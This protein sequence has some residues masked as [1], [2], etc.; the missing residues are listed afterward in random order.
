MKNYVGTCCMKLFF[1]YC[2]YYVSATGGW[3]GTILIVL[4]PWTWWWR[5]CR[6]LPHNSFTDESEF[7]L[8][9][10]YNVQCWQY[11]KHQA[12]ILRKVKELQY[13]LSGLPCFLLILNLYVWHKKKKTTLILIIK[14]IELSK[15]ICWYLNVGQLCVEYFS[16]IKLTHP[17]HLVGHVMIVV[18]RRTNMD[19]CV[20]MKTQNDEEINCLCRRKDHIHV[21]GILL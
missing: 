16:V 5:C 11:S 15:W 3:S 7:I 17:E 12:Y 6:S 2:M 8:H 18:K 20:L 4:E 19:P 13:Y 21:L 9:F 1:S 10:N 14:L